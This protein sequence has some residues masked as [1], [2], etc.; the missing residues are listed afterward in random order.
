M[1]GIRLSGTDKEAR[2]GTCTRFCGI[3]AGSVKWFAREGHRHWRPLVCPW[4]VT[5]T[6]PSFADMHN[7][8]R[9]LSVRQ[10]LLSLA[11]TGPGARKLQQLQE[12]TVT[13][14]T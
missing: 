3:V 9:R 1:L 6:A 10:Q 14:A 8:L 13:L 11:V 2:D 5:K 12:N 7:T 4:Y